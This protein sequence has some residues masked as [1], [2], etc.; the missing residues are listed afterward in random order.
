MKAKPTNKAKAGAVTLEL[1][2]RD[3][4]LMAAANRSPFKIQRI[5]VPIDFSDCSKKALLYALPFAR[6]HQ[7]AITLLY[8]VPPAYGAS[9]SSGIDYAELE[10]SMKE[11][12]QKELDKLSA[13]TAAG[14]V[15]AQALVC[16]GSP[17]REIVET[18]RRLPADLIVISTHGRTGLK[19]VFLGSV[20]EHV[21]QRA[22]CPIF[23]VR[24]NEHEILAS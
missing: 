16:V 15:S 22:P 9:E 1:R 20:A 13:A 8:V 11:G 23:V 19:H 7:A 3:E 12:G 14:D 18:A 5:L 2:R 21:V 4:P 10:A 6:D 24:E 17:A